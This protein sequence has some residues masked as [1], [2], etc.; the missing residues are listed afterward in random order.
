MGISN[1]SRNLVSF[2]R[3]LYIRLK[4]SKEVSAPNHTAKGKLVILCEADKELNHRIQL[5]A[6]LKEDSGT[7]NFEIVLLENIASPILQGF[8][9][10]SSSNSD[11]TFVINMTRFKQKITKVYYHK[12]LTKIRDVTD[13]KLTESEKRNILKDILENIIRITNNIP[14]SI[15]FPDGEDVCGY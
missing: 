15:P 13:Y 9:E 10:K 4:S 12:V 5:T 11:K 8:I 3:A 2:I 1:F 14:V 7:T 6:T